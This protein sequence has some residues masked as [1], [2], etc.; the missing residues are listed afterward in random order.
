[1]FLT[2]NHWTARRFEKYPNMVG[3]LEY[4]GHPERSVICYKIVDEIHLRQ[5]LEKQF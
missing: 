3:I 4:D 5:M 1:M 2:R